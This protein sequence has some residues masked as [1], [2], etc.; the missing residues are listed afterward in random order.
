MLSDSEVL[1]PSEK[2]IPLIKFVS[3]LISL[4]DGHNRPI[5]IECPFKLQKL[6]IDLFNHAAYLLNSTNEHVMIEAKINR[7]SSCPSVYPFSADVI[8]QLLYKTKNIAVK[9]ICFVLRM[10]KVIKYNIHIEPREVQ[11]LSYMIERVSEDLDQWK[12]KLKTEV[13]HPHELIGMICQQITELGYLTKEFV[14]YQ[15]LNVYTLFTRYDIPIQRAIDAI[16]DTLLPLATPVHRKIVNEI[17]N[18]GDKK[19]PFIGCPIRFFKSLSTGEFTCNCGGP[20]I[21]HTCILCDQHYCILCEE[22]LTPNHVCS[23]DKLS[24][25]DTIRS[26]TVQCPK[27][28]IRIEK[29]YGCDHMY[30]TQCKCNFDWVTG[31]I[32]KESEQT[33]DIYLTDLS[34]TESEFSYYINAL[35]ADYETYAIEDINAY[36]SKLC[37]LL[38]T[39][40]LGIF[41][42]SRWTRSIALSQPLSVI[43][44]N[45]IAKETLTALRSAV[46]NAIKNTIDILSETIDDYTADVI[47]MRITEKGIIALRNML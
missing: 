19:N 22:S 39:M 42:E 12:Y 23:H 21:D 25:M 13:N 11:S 17:I 37:Y 3:T 35:I 47:A 44:R 33:N 15:S 20:I 28:H 45:R 26:T 2:M 31:K 36:K 34:E 4:R 40:R 10:A 6:T 38:S 46:A 8:Q 7:I 1:E 30:C 29:A 41:D 32:I 27:C 24:S 43:M 9:T 18:C 14:E 5:P 16:I